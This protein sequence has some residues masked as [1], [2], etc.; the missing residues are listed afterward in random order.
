MGLG[1]MQDS[2]ALRQALVFA[3]AAVIALQ[4]LFRF[5]RTGL[6]MRAVVDDPDLLGLK[7]TS[8]VRV[9]RTA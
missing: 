7:G 6:A 8:P 5:T 4:V 9:R 1:V 3:V 2:A